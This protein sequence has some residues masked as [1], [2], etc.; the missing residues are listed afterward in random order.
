MGVNRATLRGSGGVYIMKDI[1][2]KAALELAIEFGYQKI[3][4][5]Q[6]ALAAGCST[7]AVSKA[8]G[9][10]P[11]LRRALMGY[12]IARRCAIV[13]AQGLAV[14]DSRALKANAKMREEAARALL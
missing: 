5:D 12:A 2:L 1:I 9:T 13:V 11:Q 3:T 10:M 6:I 7:G 14:K 8:L 4:R